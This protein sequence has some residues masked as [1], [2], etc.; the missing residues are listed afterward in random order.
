MRSKSSKK[1][2]IERI[3]T[4][5][6]ALFIITFV[7]IPFLHNHHPDFADHET[8]PAY[9]LEL[10]CVSCIILF[11]LIINFILPLLNEYL[12]QFQLFIDYENSRGFFQRRAPP[13]H[14]SYWIFCIT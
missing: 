3:L 1:I 9:L 14:S 7:M 5:F 6:A 13:F 12:F 2:L 8:C 11:I 4:G 10:L